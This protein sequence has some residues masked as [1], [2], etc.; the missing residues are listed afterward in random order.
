MLSR[1]G[2]RALLEPF[3][4]PLADDSI[5][6]V[7]VY[8]DLLFHWNRRIN[9]TAIRTPEECVTRH[10]GESLFL[11]RLTTLRGRLL[12]VGSGAGFPG[13]PLKL[14]SGDLEVVLLEPVAKKRAFL[15]EVSRACGLTG[16]DVLGRRLEEYSQGEPRPALDII[17]IRA[18]GGLESLVPIAKSLLKRNSRLCLYLGSQQARAI[19]AGGPDWNWQEPVAIPLS[20]DRQI[21]QGTRKGAQPE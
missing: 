17:T 11:S 21:L 4:I 18:V 14:I 7:I 15:K 3:E 6:K 1:N 10:F 8:L 20:H 13:L 9:L 19:R 16:V 12:D 5:D 2:V